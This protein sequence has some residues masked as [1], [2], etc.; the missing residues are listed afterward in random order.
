MVSCSCSAGCSHNRFFC[1]RCVLGSQVHSYD[2]LLLIF[3]D[4]VPF[5]CCN[6]SAARD[7]EHTAILGAYNIEPSAVTDLTV[8]ERGCGDTVLLSKIFLFLPKFG[9]FALVVFGLLVS[10]PRWLFFNLSIIDSVPGVC[11]STSVLLMVC[12][13]VVLQ[14]QYH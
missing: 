13:E 14:P 12:Q 9:I 3:F 6:V 7:C 8:Y 1:S 4:S 5:S 11:S 2:Q 10:W